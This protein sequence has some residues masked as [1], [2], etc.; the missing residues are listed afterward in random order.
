MLSFLSYAFRRSALR[1]SAVMYY[2]TLSRP[3]LTEV[4][5]HRGWHCVQSD[6]QQPKYGNIRCEIA[7][8]ELG[9]QLAC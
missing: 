2:P 8:Q 7:G 3:V 6:I 4:K 5:Q 9:T 1:Y